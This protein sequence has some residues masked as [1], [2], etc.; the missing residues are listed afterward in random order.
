MTALSVGACFVTVSLVLVLKAIRILPPF[1]CL[2]M[3]NFFEYHASSKN[4]YDYIDRFDFFFWKVAHLIALTCLV[5]L[6]LGS[7]TL[8]GSLYRY[9]FV[10]VASHLNWRNLMIH[11]SHQSQ[12]WLISSSK[13]LFRSLDDSKPFQSCSMLTN[14]FIFQKKIN[15]C[16][17]LSLHNTPFLGVVL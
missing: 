5:N 11:L 14:I 4:T 1:L 15:P 7:G 13:K 9:Y 12:M 16:L 2:H 6:F 8:S 3:Y 17:L 10:V